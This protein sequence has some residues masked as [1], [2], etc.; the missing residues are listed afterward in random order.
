MPL[1]RAE[2]LVIEEVESG[3]VLLSPVS[4]TRLKGKM[5]GQQSSW[6]ASLTFSGGTMLSATGEMKLPKT[7]SAKLGSQ[8]R[9][10]TSRL[11]KLRT[12]GPAT[13]MKGQS[14]PTASELLGEKPSPVTRKSHMSSSSQAGL[15]ESL[16]EGPKSLMEL[17]SQ[18]HVTRDNLDRMVAHGILRYVW[19]PRGVGL[20]FSI[21]EKGLQQLRQFRAALFEIRK[22]SGKKLISAKTRTPL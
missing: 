14:Q 16:E 9:V 8:M 5:L 17:R 11:P 6:K 15:L 12:S 10:G 20:S 3:R 13:I 4:Q 2:K 19:G 1:D 21:T 7:R 18:F 22:L